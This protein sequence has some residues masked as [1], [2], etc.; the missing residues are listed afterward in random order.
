MKI[1]LSP[2]DVH[3]SPI[4]LVNEFTSKLIHFTEEVSRSLLRTG[5]DY[6][7]Y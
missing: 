1:F 7:R 2:G 4:A 6:F 3:M 5:I